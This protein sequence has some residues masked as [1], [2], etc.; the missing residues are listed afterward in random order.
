[1]RW[2]RKRKQK[3]RGRFSLK[4]IIISLLIPVFLAGIYFIFSS[5]IFSIKSVEIHLSKIDCVDENKIRTSSN[6][7]GENFF[8]L[9]Y[10]KI[11]KSLKKN[12]FCIKSVSISKKF[13]SLV[14]LD[15]FGR[16][17]AVILVSLSEEATQSGAIESFIQAQATSSAQASQSA[18]IAF[19]VI[20]S[21]E[22]FVVD[23]EGIIFSKNA[24]QYNAQHIYITGFKLTLGKAIE[25]KMIGNALKILEKIKTFGMEFKDAKIL[26]EKI[27]LVNGMP[28]II[29]K[30]D[31]DIEK[32]TASLQLI[33]K[34]A[35]IDSNT[36]E[37]I[38]LRF[39]KPVVKFAPK[40]K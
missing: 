14:K 23:D 1:M 24:D 18:Q 13:P 36:L 17:A 7:L 12:F 38:D 34:T 9:H 37:F 16:E 3:V 4:K 21:N 2:N 26:S 19:P 28:K 29:F 25:D 31:G 15:V 33:L 30:L 6:L 22:K 27:L 8:F 5:K 10:Q 40:K 35:K 32:Q 39:D 20:G 11:E